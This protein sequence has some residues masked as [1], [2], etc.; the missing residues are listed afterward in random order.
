MF[1][2]YGT[3]SKNLKTA[4][5]KD[6]ICPHCGTEADIKYT[7]FGRYVHVFWIPTVAMKQKI[8]AEC[9]QC[10]KTFEFKDS[11]DSF[12]RKYA[13]QNDTKPV[14][15]PLWYY[16]GGVVLLSILFLTGY[17]LIENKGKE[18]IYI[19]NPQSGDVYRIDFKDS[20]NFT[21]LKVNS[22][23][24]DSVIVFLNEYETAGR[25]GIKEIDIDANYKKQVIFSKEQLQKMYTDN[26][27]YQI[28]RD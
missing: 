18:K 9:Q 17:K 16:S 21:T 4:I 10:Y 20:P 8:I 24:A 28:D 15:T 23:T 12:K 19:K 13:Q 1:V 27:I 25:S 3:T 2:T 6:V 26:E 14:K 5:V 22:V 11:P 7:V